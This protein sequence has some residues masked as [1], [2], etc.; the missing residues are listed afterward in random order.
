MG[1]V[2]EGVSAGV[3]LIAVVVGVTTLLV[4]RQKARKA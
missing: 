4:C 2:I 1:G 3:F